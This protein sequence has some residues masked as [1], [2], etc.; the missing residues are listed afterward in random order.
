[1]ASDGAVYE[2]ERAWLVCGWALPGWQ[3]VAEGLGGGIRLRLVAAAARAVDLY[4]HRLVPDA[5]RC[6]T[7]PGLTT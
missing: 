7:C 2:G 6:S 3:P 5:V 4:R 1:M